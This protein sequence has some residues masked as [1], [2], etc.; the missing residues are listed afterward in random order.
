MIARYI[1]RAPR[2]YG[3]EAAA[4]MTIFVNPSA[5]A[6]R[7]PSPMSGARS[8]H[9]CLRPFLSLAESLEIDGVLPRGKNTATSSWNIERRAWDREH[10]V[11]RISEVRRRAWSC[12]RGLG[13]LPDSPPL[14]KRR[15]RQPRLDYLRGERLGPTPRKPQQH[16]F[17][18]Y[19]ARPFTA[20]MPQGCSVLRSQ[21]AYQS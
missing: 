7:P 19:F 1:R 21:D 5:K 13:T 20:A 6:R 3:R 16:R 12:G 8:R 2:V 17:D 11:R 15:D 9:L 14:Q 10:A 4:L 18:P